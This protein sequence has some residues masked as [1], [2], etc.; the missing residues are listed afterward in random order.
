MASLDSEISTVKSLSHAVT[1][2]RL[3]VIN[4]SPAENGFSFFSKQKSNV[5]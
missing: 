5:I 3:D 2:S 1:T 4:S